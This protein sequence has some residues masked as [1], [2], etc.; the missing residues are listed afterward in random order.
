[1]ATGFARYATDAS[2][3]NLTMMNLC[4]ITRCTAIALLAIAAGAAQSAV[5]F[6][7]EP[8]PGVNGVQSDASTGALTQAFTVAPGQTL[9][10]VEWFGYHLPF[11]GG[12][13]TDA[14]TLIVNGLDVT[15]SALSLT[16]TLVLSS[17]GF[18]MYRYTLD[19]VDIPISSGSLELA[20]GPDTQW[21]WQYSVA[22]TG[23]T[24][25]RLIGADASTPV[26]EPAGAALALAALVTMAACSRTARRRQPGR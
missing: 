12:P 14:F 13:A 4:S 7:Q 26:P 9:A 8:L 2:A 6:S 10:S 5:L 19:I 22:S 16:S 11:S 1:M 18:D 23:L 17:G 20:N 24:A 25:F 15:G 3:R 21:A